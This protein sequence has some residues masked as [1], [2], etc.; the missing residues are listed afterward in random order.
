VYLVSATGLKSEEDVVL[1]GALLTRCQCTG[2][3]QWGWGLDGS[4]VQGDFLSPYV[5]PVA[6]ELQWAQPNGNATAFPQLLK[7]LF[8]TLNNG[9]LCLSQVLRIHQQY[10]INYHRHLFALA[11]MTP[12]RSHA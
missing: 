9:T 11:F 2:R 3:G 4:Q 6:F 12:H 8:C 1:G 5:T 7:V 10:L